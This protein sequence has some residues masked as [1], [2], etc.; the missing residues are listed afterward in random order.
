M[1]GRWIID[2]APINDR[3]LRCPSCGSRQKSMH[4]AISGGGEVVR[5]CPDQ[6]HDGDPVT[7]HARQQQAERE[8]A[9]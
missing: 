6:W 2:T 5:I 8:A 1:S 9:S 7:E 4:P 3:P